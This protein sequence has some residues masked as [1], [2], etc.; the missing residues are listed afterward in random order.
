MAIHTLEPRPET[1][2]G[3]FSRDLKPVLTI[4]PGDTVVYKVLDSGWNAFDQ[5][6]PITEKE[7]F[8]PRDREKNPGHALHGPVA[9]RGARPGMVLEIFIKEIQPGKWGW[10]S[11]GGYDSPWNRTLNLVEG[12]EFMLYWTLSPEAGTAA[13]Q[14][15]W[16]VP[17]KP[18]MG[19]LGMPPNEPGAHSTYVPRFCGGNIDCRELTAGSRLFLPV[20]VPEALF[21]VGD[22]HAVQGDGE[23]AGPALECPMERVELEFRLH[24]NMRLAWPRAHTPAGWIT[25]GLDPDLNKAWVIALE[26]MLDLIQEQYGLERKAALALAGLVVNL[27]ITQVVNFSFGVHAVLP[28]GVARGIKTK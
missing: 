22:G 16:T 26:G 11:A 4:D 25:F 2:H 23:A 5:R 18:I 9:I 3:Y 15:G 21:S 6:L 12:E 13:N 7:K 17:L 19:I 14:L 24:E 27:R 10:S 20:S 28:D 8:K 1:L